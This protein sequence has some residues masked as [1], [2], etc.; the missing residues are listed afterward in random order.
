MPKNVCVSAVLVGGIFTH[1]VLSKY[2]T[3]ICDT[4]SVTVITIQ[5]HFGEP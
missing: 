1:I 4:D 5:V 2:L 3:C